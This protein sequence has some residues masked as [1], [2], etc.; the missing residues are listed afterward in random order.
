M[1]GLGL[2]WPPWAL[3]GLELALFGFWTRQV[4]CVLFQSLDELFHLF[5][6]GNLGIA[7]VLAPTSPV[8]AGRT[9]RI[10]LFGHNVG[11]V[12]GDGI[13]LAAAVAALHFSAFSFEERGSPIVYRQT[14]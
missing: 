11:H 5:N 4:S 1:M 2:G 14:G 7:A 9:N 6:R 3:G 8:G 13:D 10:G 12:F